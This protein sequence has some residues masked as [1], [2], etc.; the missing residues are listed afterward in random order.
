MSISIRNIVVPVR[1]KGMCNSRLP[2]LRKPS[3]GASSPPMTA[4][5]GCAGIITNRYAPANSANFHT[6]ARTVDIATQSD[7]ALVWRGNKVFLRELKR[8]QLD[9][10]IIYQSFGIIVV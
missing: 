9:Y 7:S 4:R 8:S 3:P 10:N 5:N 2:S 1:S 6:S